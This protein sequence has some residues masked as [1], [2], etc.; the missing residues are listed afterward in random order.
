MPGQSQ[1]N[2]VKVKS[3][4]WGNGDTILECA[5]MTA[6]SN[7]MTCRRT[8]K[9]ALALAPANPSGGTGPLPA[10]DGINPTPPDGNP[11]KSDQIRPN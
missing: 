7:S 6:L 10:L 5:G 4:P 11:G 9:A 3:Q 8:P 1:S 2:L